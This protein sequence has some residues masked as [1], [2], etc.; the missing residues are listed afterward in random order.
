VRGV[1]LL[2]GLKTSVLQEIRRVLAPDE[3]QASRVTSPS[4]PQVVHL[5]SANWWRSRSCFCPDASVSSP[6]SGKP[7]ALCAT[8]G[9]LDHWLARFRQRTMTQN[10]AGAGA[11]VG[12]CG[13]AS[14]CPAGLVQVV[15]RGSPGRRRGDPLHGTGIP[16]ITKGRGCGRRSRAGRTARLP[17]LPWRSRR[18]G[19]TSAGRNRSCLRRRHRPSGRRHSA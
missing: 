1:R 14:G 13:S 11:L 2:L 18:R 8:S 17:N 19:P 16:A 10:V 15:R 9:L 6:A 4:L 12:V 3:E 7:A 5:R